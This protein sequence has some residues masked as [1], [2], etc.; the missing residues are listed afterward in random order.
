MVGAHT[1][2]P[3]LRVK[4]HPDRFVSGWQ[5][6]ALHHSGVPRKDSKGRWLTTDGRVWDESMDERL[7][8]WIANEG[9]RISSIVRPLKSM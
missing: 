8:D 3:N 9:I 7:I 6:V 1:A 2:S 5:V 4:Q